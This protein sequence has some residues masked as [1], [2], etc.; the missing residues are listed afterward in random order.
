MSGPAQR[1]C[2]AVKVQFAGFGLVDQAME[3]TAPTTLLGKG[4]F[5]GDPFALDIAG[6]FATDR[7]ANFLPRAIW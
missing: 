3:V 5:E 2:A 6:T 1:P 4:L 7:A